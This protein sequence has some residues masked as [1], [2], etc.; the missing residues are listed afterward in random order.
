MYVVQLLSMC[1]PQVY[2]HPSPPFVASLLIVAH[3]KHKNTHKLLQNYN[4]AVV[5][6]ANQVLLQ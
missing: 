3:Y 1:E 2:D 6:A 4:W 5:F